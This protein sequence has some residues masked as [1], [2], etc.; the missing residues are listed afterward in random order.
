[1]YP[2]PRL[3]IV[4]INAEP[5]NFSLQSLQLINLITLEVVQQNLPLTL[6]VLPVTVHI[7]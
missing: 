1:M 2:E 6:Y 4:L 3:K 7:N 5:T